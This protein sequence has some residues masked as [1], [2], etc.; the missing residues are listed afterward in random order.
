M[1]LKPSTLFF[2]A[3]ETT[4]LVG[5]SGS[6]KSTVGSLLL[7]FYQP[8]SG[9]IL[10]DGRD[11]E[12]LSTSWLRNNITL[13]QQQS[14]LFDETI[15]RNV[16]F[17]HQDY[18]GVSRGEIWEAL[19]FAA[20]QDTIRRLPRGIDTKVGNGGAALSGGQRQRIALARAK[21]RNTPILILDESTSALDHVSRNAVMEAIKFWR[22]GKT[23]I[24]ITHDMSQ[25]A[26]DDFVYFLQDGSIRAEG[27]RQKISENLFSTSAEAVSRPGVRRQDS[28][29]EQ[30]NKIAAGQ[31][32]AAEISVRR[33]TRVSQY[34][35]GR[36][37]KLVHDV[38]AL[39]SLP[40]Q[41][42]TEA[43][44]KHT[45]EKEQQHL[46]QPRKNPR[47][48]LS[49]VR[50]SIAMKPITHR[51]ITKAQA[52]PGILAPARKDTQMEMTEFEGL[53]ATETQSQNLSIRRLLATVWPVLDRMGRIQL[54]MGFIATCVQAVSPPV[55]AFLL[56]KLFQTF[57]M[58]TGYKSKALI[59]ALSL[60][61]VAVV[62]GLASFFMRYFLEAAAQKWV[63][64]LRIE[65]FM[66]ILEQPKAWFDDTTNSPSYLTSALERNAEEMRNLLSRFASSILIVAILVTVTTVW[67]LVTCWKLT[68]VAL[69]TSPVIYGLTKAFDSVSS[70]WESRTNVSNDEIGG[71][72]SET[73]SDIR[74]V[75]SLTLES[76]FHRKYKSATAS[77]FSVGLRRA[78]YGG[79]LYG[80]SS[81]T[82]P[83]VVALIFYYG[84]VLAKRHEFS[85]NDVLQAFSLITFSTTAANTIISYMPQLASS[86]DTGNRL[87]RL[88]RLPLQSHELEGDLKP[89]PASKTSL[90]GPIRFNDLTFYYP[91]RPQ[92][93]ALYRVNL[94][95][96]PAICTAIVGGSGSGKSTI[97]SL[98]LKLYPALP[99]NHSF[100][101][102]SNSSYNSIPAYAPLIVSDHDICNLNTTIYRTFIALVPQTPVIFPVTVLENICYGLTPTS[103]FRAEPNIHNAAQLAGIHDF[104][105]S[106]P[107]GYNTVLGD[108]GGLGVSGGQAQ[109]IVIARAL[110]RK[111][112]ILL[113]DEPTSALDAESAAIIRQTI[114]L[115]VE[116]GTNGG[117]A[118]T[119]VVITHSREMMETAD[120]IAVL[121]EG[122]CVETG[123]FDELMARRGCLWEMLSQ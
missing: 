63:D 84:T 85:V 37:A 79:I 93:P 122:Q 120:H 97:A 45:L 11:L 107:D 48:P 42:R 64:A 81:S 7:R 118:T 30:M 32:A 16:A 22:Q 29:E 68:L 104:I 74:T 101:S 59:Y 99:H 66:R 105:L 47:Q 44:T 3:G 12:D 112:R 108:Q 20:I 26:D 96:P 71:I 119:I 33:L 94:T 13:V 17:G 95:I 67:A 38:P 89:D 56:V 25:I 40:L 55:I 110:V 54:L 69:S 115:L 58:A 15:S 78:S 34:L 27:L 21:L 39:P 73:F 103:P 116:K 100:S 62:D 8:S 24:I 87:L 80:L 6:G 50:D 113:M 121:R 51:S 18:D 75:R 83:F 61:G 5:R 91:T 82:V 57:Y 123:S 36:Q 88:S 102:N 65:A 90:L 35:G 1:V 14:I 41:H 28:L 92:H 19:D 23:T 53:I 77:A 106:L 49:A 86:L 109:R 111:P 72:F 114:R 76:Y 46:Q 2:P 31:G 52:P 43:A 117:R 10:L 4:F 70:R 60:L 98:L 9:Q